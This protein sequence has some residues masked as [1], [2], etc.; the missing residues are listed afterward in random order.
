MF[1]TSGFFKKVLLSSQKHCLAVS[2]DG[3]TP[4]KLSEEQV[5]V[6]VLLAS[7]TSKGFSMMYIK[8]AGVVLSYSKRPAKNT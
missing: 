3:S 6:P 1:K 2:G 7:T 4:S 8:L 5:T